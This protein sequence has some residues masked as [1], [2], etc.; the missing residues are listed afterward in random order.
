MNYLS[1]IK[2]IPQKATLGDGVVFLGKMGEA[3]FKINPG[4]IK[5]ELEKNALTELYTN[6]SKIMNVSAEE[7]TG[8]ICI[9]L[10]I[11]DIV[12]KEVVKNS[13][14]AYKITVSEEKINIC[15][16]GE[17]GL[18]YAVNT[19][20]KLINV[21]NNEVF[22]PEVEIIDYP[23][24]KI[25][26]HFVESRFGSNLMTFEDWKAVI[27]DMAD[28]K[29]NQLCVSLYGCWFIQYDMTPSNYLFLS[30]PKYPKLKSDVIKK[31]YSPRNKEWINEVA[32]VPMAKEDF[33]G[34]LIVYGKSRGIEVLPLW[35]SL[36][37]NNLLAVHYP[38]IAAP[39]Y[40]DGSVGLTSLC[41]TSKQALDMLFGIY[42]Y[43]IDKYLRPN[44]IKS[45]HVG[46][47]EVKNRAGLD[48]NNPHKIFSPWCECDECSKYTPQ[49]LL[50][51]HAIRILKHLKSRG[52]ESVFIYSDTIMEIEDADKFYN[53]L[54]ENDVLD[55]CVV[56][57]WKYY[58]LNNKRFMNLRPDLG[59][60]SVV[61][62]WNSYTHWALLAVYTENSRIL[63]EMAIRDGAEGL[64]SYCAW[65]KTCDINHL[66]MASYSWNCVASGDRDTFKR[67][68]AESR[69]PTRIEDAVLALKLF[70]DISEQGPTMPSDTSSKVGA[71]YFMFGVCCYYAYGFVVPTMPYPR[72]FPGEAVER[73]LKYR[74][75]LEK[76]LRK[77]SRDAN[78]AYKI[79]ADI[80]K[81]INCDTALARRYAC[82][83]RNYRD[84]ADDYLAYLKI[85]DIMQKPERNAE[86]SKKL[87]DI[88]T[89]RKNERLAI[90]IEM[91]SFKEDY[92]LPSHLRNQSLILQVF[93]DLESYLNTTLPEDVNIDMTDT[94]AI[95][96]A[97]F[98]KLR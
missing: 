92:L 20:L 43:I 3:D 32:E 1:K 93:S 62:P 37:H 41:T 87:L 76:L 81:D 80:A 73:I 18:Y 97:N 90:M 33:F 22:V 74:K 5:T 14:Q 53:L 13:D 65:D 54:K 55:V 95:S 52:M 21:K 77:I 46:L 63:S 67:H 66:A 98:K 34:D 29:M 79:F 88:V 9:D 68:Y 45:F 64:Q 75:I 11:S 38:E 59:V 82:E 12:P 8:K 60:R 44:G 36:G 17:R 30:I 24:L 2:P 83:L 89:A 6:I 7:M 26:G 15:G 69:F 49:E 71:G 47:D 84:I 4:N 19:F 10:E 56:D 85:Y 40:K 58:N 48:S 91:E 35:N 23:D 25:R 31:Y 96:S 72:R 86:V 42:D 50:F 61:K 16:Y 70:E 51:N 94:S 39:K 28:M 78:K 57:W 27:D